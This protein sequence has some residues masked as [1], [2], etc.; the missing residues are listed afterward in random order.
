MNDQTVKSFSLPFAIS[1][2]GPFSKTFSLVWWWFA[3]CP[4]PYSACSV[5]VSAVAWGSKNLIPLFEWMFSAHIQY[6]EVAA[7]VTGSLFRQAAITASMYLYTHTHTYLLVRHS[8]MR[9]HRRGTA[10]DN[11][12]GL[13]GTAAVCV[14]HTSSI[15]AIAC[16]STWRRVR[17]NALAS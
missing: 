15:I 17:L 16:S 13:F 14:I 4:N 9:Q 10:E 1:P 2:T 3:F 7:R 6:A 11:S 8:C 12:A 5:L